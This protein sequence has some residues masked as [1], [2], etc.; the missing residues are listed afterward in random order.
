M[1]DDEELTIQHILPHIPKWTEEEI[2]LFEWGM[3]KTKYMSKEEF[4]KEFGVKVK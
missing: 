3:V 2:E 4:E 1:S